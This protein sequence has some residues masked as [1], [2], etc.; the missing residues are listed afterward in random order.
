MLKEDTECYIINTSSL[1]G[2]LTG[3]GMAMYNVTKH[4]VVSL[5]ECLYNE[6]NNIK[7]KLK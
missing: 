2:L 7:L 6:L 5:S 4:G 3:G 1:A